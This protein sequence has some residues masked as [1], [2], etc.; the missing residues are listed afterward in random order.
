MQPR[1]WLFLRK[2]TGFPSGFKSAV[3]EAHRQAV[4]VVECLPDTL[5]SSCALR[6][7]FAVGQHARKVVTFDNGDA[8]QSIA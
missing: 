7:L 1:E 5:G 4:P 2:P 3:C 8:A 6:R